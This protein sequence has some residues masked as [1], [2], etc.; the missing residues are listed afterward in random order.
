MSSYLFQPTNETLESS[1]LEY[2]LR[3]YQ[4][5]SNKPITVGEVAKGLSIPFSTAES[6]V[7]K[8]DLFGS[9]LVT[10]KN[11]GIKNKLIE[12]SV[13]L[14]ANKNKY[15]PVKSLAEKLGVSVHKVK[16]VLSKHNLLDDCY[17]L[18]SKNEE[19]IVE[20]ITNNRYVTV[21]ELANYAK[22]TE[23]T[24][25]RIINKLRLRDKGI[26]V[27]KDEKTVLE[28]TDL[29]THLRVSDICFL[30]GLSDTSVRNISDKFNLIEEGKVVTVWQTR[31]YKN[32]SNKVAVNN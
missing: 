26:I 1:V 24:V 32:S 23:P 30:S 3:H 28:I 13:L 21:K 11:T 17:I 25:N 5:N 4:L 15:T 16:M 8:L 29:F 12:N 22:C 20:Y 27:T 18:C 2:L 31:K 6:V 7:V 14:V 19:M 9:G 10:E